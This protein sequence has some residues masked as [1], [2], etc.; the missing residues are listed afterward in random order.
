M[1][2]YRGPAYDVNRGHSERRWT[3]GDDTG[4]GPEQGIHG[5]TPQGQT[6]D[7]ATQVRMKY[8]CAKTEKEHDST[9]AL[10][11]SIA[12]HTLQCEPILRR[13]S[14]TSAKKL[15][16]DARG[17]VINCM[18]RTDVSLAPQRCYKQPSLN[19]LWDHDAPPKLKRTGIGGWLF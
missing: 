19:K 4:I 9:D 12:D 18:V 8:T 10:G 2:A 15:P 11:R 1:N 13:S 6:C 14:L 5:P 16:G 7:E 17:W 3:D